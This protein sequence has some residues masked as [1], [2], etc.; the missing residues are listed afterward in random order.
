MGKKVIIIFIN[1]TGQNRGLSGLKNIWPVIMTVDMLSVILSLGRTNSFKYEK[2]ET[3]FLGFQIVHA[4]P[5]SRREITVLITV[6]S[7]QTLVYP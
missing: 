3:G 4:I 7:A 5:R 2:L 6:E 1:L